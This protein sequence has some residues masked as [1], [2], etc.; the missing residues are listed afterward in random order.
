[1]KDKKIL[2]VCRRG[3]VRSVAVK[4]ILNEKG[5]YNVLSVGGLVVPASTLNML[6]EWAETIL[7]AKPEH[8]GR[9]DPKYENKINRAFYMGD[10]PE[11]Q[12]K[13]Q[14]KVIDL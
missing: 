12:A 7:L 14:L 3:Y 5:F 2:C 8:G 1:M 6:C 4:K 11:E 9:I 10:D 13:K